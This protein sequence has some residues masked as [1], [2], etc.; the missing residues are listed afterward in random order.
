MTLTFDEVAHQYFADGEPVPNVTRIL[1]G[2]TDYSHIPADTLA[3]AQEEGKA[4]HRMVE[5]DCNGQLES[6]PEWMDGHRAAWLRFKGEV[7][8]EPI[9]S[10]H[11][12]FHAGQRYAGTLDLLGEIRH[13]KNAKGICLIDVKRSFYAGPVIGLQTAAYA[14]ALRS[15]KSMPRVDH[16]FALRLDKNGQYRLQPYPDGSDAA[17]FIAQ[18]TTY[19]WKEKHGRT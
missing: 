7:G 11:R 2:L 19:R 15:D 5:L 4:V 3:R 14:E 18:L 10:E 13:L 12:V 17:V 8:F 9:L 16:R 6:V 1:S